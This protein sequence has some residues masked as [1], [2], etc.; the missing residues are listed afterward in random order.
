MINEKSQNLLEMISTLLAEDVSYP[1]ENTLLFAWFDEGA[2]A[3]SIFK[4]LQDRIVYRA[5]DLDVLAD[6]LIALW[7][8]QPKERRWAEMEYFIKDGKFDVKFVYPEE[9][10]PDEMMMA[11][12]TQ[13][14]RRYLGTD[15]IYYPQP[16]GEL[17]APPD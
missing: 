16:D 8:E 14:V 1:L 9:L 4:K 12:R 3:P 2:V 5:P 6:T 15:P 17:I 7:E 10:D 11:H 13:V